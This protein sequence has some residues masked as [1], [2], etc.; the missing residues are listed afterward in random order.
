MFPNTKV[1]LFYSK[2]HFDVAK[3]GLQIGHPGHGDHGDL[4]TTPMSVRSFVSNP[5]E[6]GTRFSLPCLTNLMPTKIECWG[7][8]YPRIF[9]HF[10]DRRL[11]QNTWKKHIHPIL[12]LIVMNKACHGMSRDWFQTPCHV[13]TKPTGLP[14]IMIIMRRS[15]AGLS[16]TI[17]SLFGPLTQLKWGRDTDKDSHTH[18]L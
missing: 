15:K 6:I 13:P 4:S 17:V 11:K 5:M 8:I 18:I 1:V 12:P 10:S 7:E 9:E 14:F 3:P 16:N 2:W